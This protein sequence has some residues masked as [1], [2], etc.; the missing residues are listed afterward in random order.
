MPSPSCGLHQRR[1]FLAA[2]AASALVFA[3]NSAVF[4]QETVP[5]QSDDPSPLRLGF[6]LYGMKSLDPVAAVKELREIGYE[7]T[8]L[9]VMTGWPADSST[10]SKEKLRELKSALA[11]Q[12]MV[13]SAIMENLLLLS[14][15]DAVQK[16]LDRLKAAAEISLALSETNPPPIETVLGGSPMRWETD[17]Q[18]MV[19]RLRTWAELLAEM[20]VPL[21]IKAH[22]S[23]AMHRPIDVLWMIAKTNSPWIKTV[24]DYSHF[25]L[26]GLSIDESLTDLLPHTAMVHVKDGKLTEAGRPEFLLPGDGMI[27]YADL[28]GHLARKHYQGDIVV[29]VTGQLHSKPDYDPLAT[30]R[31]CFPVLQTARDAVKAS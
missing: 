14:E 24:Y 30:A 16:N 2:T 28:L 10:L 9:P 3:G 18:K 27:G 15:G 22:Y 23:N 29:E 6:S 21:A 19:E 5:D 26:Q 20:K 7:T 25:Q 17:R 4:S 1:Q 12:K 31:K 8:E 11:D 13:M